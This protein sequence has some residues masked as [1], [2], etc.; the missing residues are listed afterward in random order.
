MQHPKTQHPPPASRLPPPDYVAYSGLIIDDIVLP[1]GR[2]FFNTL[3]G[4]ATHALIG[5]RVWSESLGYFAAVGDDFDPRHRAALERIGVDLRGL[6]RREGIRTAR[7]WQLFEPDERRIE[8]FRT[9]ESDFYRMEARLEEMPPAYFQARGFHVHHG[10]LLQMADVLSRL[11]AVNPGACMVWE[12]TPV[13]HSGSEEEFRGVLSRVDLVSPDL[14]EALQMTGQETLPGAIATLL[15]WGAP[16]VAVRM[17]ARGSM[18]ATADGATYAIPAV[19]AHVVDTTGAGDAY[20][21]GFLVA[22]SEGKD[23]AEAGARA[24]VSAS[25]AIEQFGVPEFDERSREEAERRL[26]WARER[27]EIDPHP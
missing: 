4:S 9:K 18:V 7:A 19:P 27:V 2:T 1:D 6:L 24:A 16:L 8:V 14:G 25:F 5:M 13:Q 23:A 21:G 15:G 20:C 22:L 3:G 11:R 12:P 17:G 26:A 10:T